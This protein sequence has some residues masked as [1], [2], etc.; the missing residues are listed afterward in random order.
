MQQT[1]GRNKAKRNVSNTKY[2]HSAVIRVQVTKAYGGNRSI[3]PRILNL[4]TKWRCVDNYKGW[5][6]YPWLGTPVP[7]CQ[8]VV[9][10]ESRNTSLQTKWNDTHTLKC[11]YG[12]KESFFSLHHSFLLQRIPVS[13]SF[14]KETT[15]QL[16]R[17]LLFARLWHS[18][19][20]THIWQSNGIPLRRRNSPNNTINSSNGQLIVIKHRKFPW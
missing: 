12:S 3:V 16:I 18:I 20:T 17:R 9:H 15:Q 13:S 19:K 2:I 8:Y 14:G 5:P 11:A 4:G 1:Y 10:Y 7:I 6:L